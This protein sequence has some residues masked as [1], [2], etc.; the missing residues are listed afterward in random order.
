MLP[1]LAGI[2]SVVPSDKAHPSLQPEKLTLCSRNYKGLSVSPNTNLCQV[3]N[4]LYSLLSTKYGSQFGEQ[5]T[6][7]RGKGSVLS[8]FQSPQLSAH[9]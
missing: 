3:G 1:F 6:N 7:I 2:S 9:Y 5:N 8:Y 4:E